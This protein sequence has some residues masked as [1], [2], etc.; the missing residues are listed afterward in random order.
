MITDSV[1]Q[2]GPVI[3]TDTVDH[4]YERVLRLI[5]ILLAGLA[6]LLLLYK[7][8]PRRGRRSADS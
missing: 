8:I 4:L 7:L 3:M 6:V 5:L 2:V 1:F